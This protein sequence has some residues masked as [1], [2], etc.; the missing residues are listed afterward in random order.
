MKTFK[1]VL[2]EIKSEVPVTP[3]GKKKKTFS[4]ADFDRLT[5]AYL[6]DVES[7]IQ[8]AGI[9][10]GEMVEKE[11]Q[12]VKLFRGMLKKILLDFGVDKQESEAMLDNYNIANVDGMYELCSEII[13]N[14]LVADKKFDFLTK[15]TFMGSLTISDIGETT[16]EYSEIGK[17]DD[18]GERKKFK[19][20]TENHQRLEKQSKAPKW[21]KKKF[22]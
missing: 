3:K 5:K 1:E 10:N 6:N 9:K 14:Y 21:L 4:R 7:T 8:V 16:K 17:K 22:E 19:V 18:D 20:T 15:K 11:V 13:Y 2:D 12:P